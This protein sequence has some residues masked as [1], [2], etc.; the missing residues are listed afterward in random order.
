MSTTA[1]AARAP[2]QERASWTRWDVVRAG[3]VAAYL[4]VIVLCLATPWGPRVFWTMA[5]PLLIMGIVV[6]GFHSWRRV[7]PLAFWG[8]LGLRFKPASR[9]VKRVPPWLER[10][11]FLVTLAFLMTMLTVRLLLINGDGLWLAVALIGLGVLAAAV[12]YVYTGKTWCNF[13]C[14]VGFVERVYTDP[15][16]PAPGGNSQ[17]VTCTACKKHCPDIEQE[18]GYWKDV[19]LTARRVSFYAFPGVVLAFYTYYYLRAGNWDAYFGGGWTH[20]QV[21]RELVFGSGFY[22]LH[23]VPA[24]VAAPLTIVLFAAASLGVFLALERALVRGTGDAE[25]GTHVTL[26]LAAFAAFN[27]FYVFA[28]APTL[29]RIPWGVHVAAFV[30]PAVASVLLIRRVKRTSEGHLKE[31]TARKLLAKWSFDEPPPGTLLEVLSFV[32]ANDR[33]RGIQ[34][35]AYRDAVADVVVD[36]VVT[37]RDL[38]LLEHLRLDLGIGEA[39]HEKIVTELSAE[40]RDL[41]DP[42]RASSV[43]LKLQLESY[44]AALAAVYTG[45]P[46]EDLALV[47]RAFGVD[48]HVHEAAVARLQ[49]D[50]SAS[51]ERA[52]LQMARVREL[53]AQEAAIAVD[54]P[55]GAAREYAL[56][57]L[58]KRRERALA[59]LAELPHGEVVES[60]PGDYRETLDALL[61]GNDRY[62]RA[63]AAALTDADSDLDPERI[64]HLAGIPLF[65]DLDL[66]DLEELS[67]R[68][69]EETF[70]AGHALCREGDETDD[71]FIV[72]AGTADVTVGARVVGTLRAGDVVGEI[73]ALDRAPRTATVT[74]AGGPLRVL[75]LAGEDF[76]GILHSSPDVADSVLAT[77]ARRLREST[78]RERSSAAD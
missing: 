33:A 55:A 38:N 78:A 60:P 52:R 8:S 29:R 63:A 17:C 67:M 47:A 49:H 32:K 65:A 24:I 12:N 11:F 16:S 74:A 44:R 1:A 34:L 39:E 43:E 22:F 68:S 53:A 42:A 76:R 40:Q 59:R 9:T 41:L 14:P 58:R 54:A 6:A 56:L 21:D 50:T 27:A 57:A 3:G 15:S 75:R 5:L 10:W 72:L 19:G 51:E 48:K 77:L 28:G 20:K 37:S 2:E 4:A 13:L 26:A 62:L 23:A 30:V 73:A 7:C 18:G 70:A 64:V 61:T 66:E 46:G 36:G 31:K 45:A 69:T 25:R 71:F 35:A